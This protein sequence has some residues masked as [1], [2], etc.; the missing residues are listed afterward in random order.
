M[1]INI[2]AYLGAAAV[3]LDAVRDEEHVVEVHGRQ[4]AEQPALVDGA[5][6]GGCV[7]ALRV[8]TGQQ[9]QDVRGGGQ[10]LPCKQSV[11]HQCL[12]MFHQGLLTHAASIHQ[13]IVV[14]AS[15]YMQAIFRRVRPHAS[16][17]IALWFL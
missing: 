10:A 13:S 9:L 2:G 7:A 17:S 12:G 4:A 1:I 14:T 5:C 3:P 6:G 11:R 8:R 16:T 15:E